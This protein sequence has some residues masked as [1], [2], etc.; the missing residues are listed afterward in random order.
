MIN[1]VSILSP[2]LIVLCLVREG[3]GREGEWRGNDLTSVFMGTW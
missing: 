2:S 1:E 3:E